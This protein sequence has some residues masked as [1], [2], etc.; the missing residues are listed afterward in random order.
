[1]CAGFAIAS[2][3]Q[4]LYHQS[5]SDVLPHLPYVVAL[6]GPA[7]LSRLGYAGNYIDHASVLGHL[8]ISASKCAAGL[9]L[10]TVV[11]SVRRVYASQQELVPEFLLTVQ[12][13]VSEVRSARSPA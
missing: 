8:L 4:A 5:Y 9:G 13:P 1:M 7:M 3:G 10:L 12:T 2:C 11:K 6:M